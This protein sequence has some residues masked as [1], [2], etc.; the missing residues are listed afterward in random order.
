MSF[1]PWFGTNWQKA[2]SV[3]FNEVACST[4]SAVFSQSTSRCQRQRLCHEDAEQIIGR[5]SN[6]PRVLCTCGHCTEIESTCTCNSL[7][8]L[9]GIDTNKVNRLHNTCCSDIT[10]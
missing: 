6:Q 7:M 9:H 2:V 3:I 1:K 10:C 4:S 8:L 5:T